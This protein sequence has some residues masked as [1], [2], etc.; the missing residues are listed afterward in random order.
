MKAEK[1]FREKA[2]QTTPDYFKFEDNRLDE[3][4]RVGFL[5]GEV[6]V[7]VHTDDGGNIPH[8]HIR[9][10]ATRGLQ[11]E[12]CVSLIKSAYF[13]HG[14]YRDT[15]NNNMARDFAVF[16]ESPSRNKKYKSNY[17]YAVD[18]W[19]DNNSNTCITPQYDE[20]GNMIIPNYRKLN[21]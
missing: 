10:T 15:M 21:V 19:N 18:M 6:E 11:F 12:T 2:G 20:N 16:M 3:M 1:R 8:V 4:A 13:L 14:H 9:D 7:Y 5:S 17:E